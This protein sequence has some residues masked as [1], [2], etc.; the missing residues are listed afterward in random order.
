[1]GKIS[2]LRSKASTNINI[3]TINIMLKDGKE[4]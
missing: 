4:M 3:I 1:M 2:P